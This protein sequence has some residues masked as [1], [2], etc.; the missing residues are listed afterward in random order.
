MEA[1]RLGN[2]RLDCGFFSL[3]LQKLLF[4]ERRTDMEM[5][6]LAQTL[7]E[8][9][10]PGRGIVIGRSE[11]GSSRLFYYGKKREQQKPDICRGG[12]GNPDS[13]V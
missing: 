3:N 1:D 7:R 10:Y 4:W 13:G 5:I 11:N 12:R 9:S 8:N 6:S 2:E